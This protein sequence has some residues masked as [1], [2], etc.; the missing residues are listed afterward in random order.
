MTKH[1]EKSHWLADSDHT[2]EMFLPRV[3]AKFKTNRFE[4]YETFSI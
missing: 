4:I 2:R 3:R 1:T